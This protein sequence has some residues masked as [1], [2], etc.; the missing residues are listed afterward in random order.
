MIA[1]MQ[2]TSGYTYGDIERDGDGE[3][4]PLQEK[5]ERILMQLGKGR[6]SQS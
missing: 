4:T 6:V 1:K 3:R 2:S 5:E